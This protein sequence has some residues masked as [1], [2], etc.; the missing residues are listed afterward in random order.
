MNDNEELYHR[1]WE[2]HG[3]DMQLIV[4]IEELSELQKAVTKFLRRKKE[5]NVLDRELDETAVAIAEEIADVEIMID[6]V[7]VMKFGEQKSIIESYKRDKISM[8]NRMFP[9]PEFEV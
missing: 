5:S 1:L 9:D 8:L 4:L 6:Q 3:E 7:K 2:K